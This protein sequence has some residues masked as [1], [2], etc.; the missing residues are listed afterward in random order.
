MIN[1]L[2]LYVR[3]EAHTA[4]SG[5]QLVDRLFVLIVLHEIH[6]RLDAV[7]FILHQA[8]R[9]TAFF[10]LLGELDELNGVV[11]LKL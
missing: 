10:E 11:L 2:G 3:Y 9:L 4:Q 1:A 8:A 6:E 7:D 5:G